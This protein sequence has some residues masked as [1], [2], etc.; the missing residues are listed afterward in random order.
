[1]PGGLLPP[2]Y[3]PYPGLIT[4][5][6]EAIDFISADIYTLN[7]GTEA[8]AARGVYE[9]FIYP[10]LVPHQKTWVVPVWMVRT[11]HSAPHATRTPEAAVGG[12]AG[13]WVAGGCS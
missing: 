7:K 9:K 8:D 6:P 12:G 11:K 3:C 5:V 2:G 4:A 1:M 13:G 10:R